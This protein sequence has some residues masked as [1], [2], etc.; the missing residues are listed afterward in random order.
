MTS[1]QLAYEEAKVID[2]SYKGGKVPNVNLRVHV[3]GD[4][5]SL[6]SVNI[7]NKAIGRWKS[8]GGNI[9]Y[10]YTHAWDQVMREQWSNVSVLA[11]IDSIDQATYARQNGYAPSLV[12]SEHPSDKVY[13]LESSDVKWIPCPAQTKKVTCEKCKL[14]MNADRL[15][16]KNMGITFSA[17][18]VKKNEIKR[19]LN[20]IK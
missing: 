1:R 6:T 18:G 17:H 9:A 12:V 4:C 2:G 15:F 19:R 10:T 3:S 5:S 7:V 8:R 13:T 11:S 16:E 14:C 20:V